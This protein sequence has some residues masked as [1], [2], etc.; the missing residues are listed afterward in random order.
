MRKKQ[1]PSP[2]EQL[3]RSCPDMSQINE[4]EDLTDMDQSQ[5]TMNDSSLI[6]SANTC[7]SLPDLNIAEH[8][9]LRDEITLLKTQLA[10]AHLEIER[11]NL[12]VSE[13]QRKTDE[14]QRES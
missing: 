12:H 1:C 3:N 8:K 4:P 6:F 2:T 14:Q 7:I 5:D 13:L 11:L 9:E 10:S